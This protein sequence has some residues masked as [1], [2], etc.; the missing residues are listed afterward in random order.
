MID[1]PWSLDTS[2]RLLGSLVGGRLTL[3][4]TA[5]VKWSHAPSSTGIGRSFGNEV[6]APWSIRLHVLHARERWL[7]TCHCRSPANLMSCHDSKILHDTLSQKHGFPHLKNTARAGS[8]EAGTSFCISFPKVRIS[9][10][11]ATSDRL[12]ELA[13]SR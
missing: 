4:T 2:T 11:R 5:P 1:S 12:R 8:S 7:L 13:T 10:T 6:S 9:P 3:G